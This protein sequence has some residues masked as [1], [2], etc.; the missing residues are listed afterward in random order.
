MHSKLAALLFSLAVFRFRVRRLDVKSPSALSPRRKKARQTLSVS[1]RE[2]GGGRG[3]EL[4]KPSDSLLGS[5]R[6]WPT[7]VTWGS[8][9]E[10]RCFSGGRDRP[11]RAERRPPLGGKR[12]TS[13]RRRGEADP[14]YHHAGSVWKQG[15][16][17]RRA[18]VLRED[19]EPCAGTPR[20]HVMPRALLVSS[21]WL[22]Q[23]LAARL[24]E[25]AECGV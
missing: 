18:S 25:Q 7:S 12:S 2:S 1:R 6:R 11:L 4:N 16:R 19:G 3:D 9:V 14:V 10:R 17:A 21:S 20:E 22:D 8:R 13:W 23:G 24:L 15:A 5:A